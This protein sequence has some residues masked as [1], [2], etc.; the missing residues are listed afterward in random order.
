MALTKEIKYFILKHLI[1]YPVYFLLNLYAKTVKVT[2]E[3][4][5]GIVNYLDDGGRVILASWHQRFFGGF[6]LPEMLNRPILIMISQSRDGDFVAD[7]AGRI[8]WRPIRGS[9]SR[10]GK[11]ALRI[12]IDEIKDYQIVGHIVDGPNGP[13]MVIKPGLISLAQH[14]SAAICPTFVFYER[15]WTFNSWDRFLVPKP[16]SSAVIRF[17]QLIVLPSDLGPEEFENVRLCIERGF[18][19][20]YEKGD[21]RWTP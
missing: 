3:N 1:S 9:S 13:P 8:G 14:S 19:T 12:L 11:Q 17:G 4:E 20:G 5:K 16:F 18:V 10:G 2:L 21:R 6:Y 7:V 15:A